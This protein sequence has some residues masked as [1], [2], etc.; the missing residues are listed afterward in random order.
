MS[1]FRPIDFG[2]KAVMKLSVEPLNPSE[3]PKLL[4]GL[5]KITKSY[6]LS[7]V[8]I[9]DSGEHI[10]FGTGELYLDCLMQDL[11][12]VFSDIEVKVS[13]PFVSI[14]ETVADASSSKCVC[15]TPNHK[16][17]ISMMA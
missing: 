8:K 5:R 7:D 12:T 6:P 9:E 13:E 2:T 1:I 14:S 10:I 15:E 3:L 17:T 16:N 4:Q 11:R